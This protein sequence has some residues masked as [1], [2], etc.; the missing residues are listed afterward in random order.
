MGVPSGIAQ[1]EQEKEKFR[2]Y[3]KN[4]LFYAIYQVRGQERDLLEDLFYYKGYRVDDCAIPNTTS[5][6]WFNYIQADIVFDNTSGGNIDER[7]LEDIKRQYA[8]GITHFHCVSD[9][10]NFAQTKENWERNIYDIVESNE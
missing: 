3:S 10:Y 7:I 2:R 1:T 5:R 9:S 6:L 4:K 8:E